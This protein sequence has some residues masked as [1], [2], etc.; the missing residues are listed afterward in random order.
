MVGKVIAMNRVRGMVAAESSAG[1]SIFELLSDDDVD[2]GDFVEWRDSTPLGRE[3]LR[4]VTKSLKF[5]VYFQNHHVS[6]TMLRQQ[7]LLREA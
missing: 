7:L 5:E 6:L 3:L 2:V 1:I 4:N